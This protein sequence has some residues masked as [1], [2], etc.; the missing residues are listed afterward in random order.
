MLTGMG[1]YAP[2]IDP[3]MIL[4]MNQA[5]L[6]ISILVGLLI[7][8]PS[9]VSVRA[10]GKVNW[11]WLVVFIP[12]FIIDSL[13]LMIALLSFSSPTDA[14]NEDVTD[15]NES[16]QEFLGKR[17]KKS[18]KEAKL[19]LDWFFRCLYVTMLILFQV[20]IAIRLDLKVDWRWSVVFIPWWIF[21]L[22]NFL[23]SS[24]TFFFVITMGVP[25]DMTAVSEEEEQA[26]RC[27]PLKISEKMSVLI[28][29][30]GF[31]VFKR[32]LPH[33]HYFIDIPGCSGHFVGD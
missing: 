24:R 5:F 9:F 29:L 2:F 22:L 27:R 1:Q 23:A 13:I 18:S 8:F 33:S 31:W 30:F 25:I 14:E 32:L 3:D 6:G 21:E 11:A 20:F 7:M 16:Q 10:D 28:D 12:A 26:I 17:Q 15:A 19:S 4:R